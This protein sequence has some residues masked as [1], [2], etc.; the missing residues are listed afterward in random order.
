MARVLLLAVALVGSAV[1]LPARAATFDFAFLYAGTPTATG[2]FSFADAL[3]GQTVSASQLTDFRITFLPGDFEQ[4]SGTYTTLSSPNFQPYFQFDS[5]ADTFKTVPVGTAGTA[6]QRVI[7]GSQSTVAG[8]DIFNLY[9]T[10]PNQPFLATIVEHRAEHGSFAEFGSFDQITVRPAL[11]P[12][13]ATAGLLGAGLAV[14]ALSRR[15]R[16]GGTDV[17]KL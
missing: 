14:A 13:P 4:A 10:I 3:L 12:E 17:R 2:A 8:A 15:G 7:S 1:I 9:A 16:T 5:G 11:V 6:V